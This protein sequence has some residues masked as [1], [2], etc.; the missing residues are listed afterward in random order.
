MIR[1]A[2][3]EILLIFKQIHNQLLYTHMTIEKKKS[4]AFLAIY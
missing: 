2:I 4:Y 1:V 3:Y